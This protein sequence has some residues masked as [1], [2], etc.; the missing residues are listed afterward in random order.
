MFESLQDP[1]FGKALDSLM[2]LC[3]FLDINQLFELEDIP[4]HTEQIHQEMFGLLAHLYCVS[5]EYNP[6]LIRWI[7]FILVHPCE[8]EELEE[9]LLRIG[10][11]F[12]ILK[13]FPSPCTMVFSSL[14]DLGSLPIT[15]LES[16]AKTYIEVL[17]TL[18][19]QAVRLSYFN[20]NKMEEALNDY[21]CVQ[22]RYLNTRELSLDLEA[23]ASVYIC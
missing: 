8:E 10:E 1:A 5:E 12:S 13:K 17:R 11:Q 9:R 6:R 15:D 22:Q 21:L 3:R 23:P 2:D 16:A 4:S 7:Q 19:R 20:Q 14:D 18:G